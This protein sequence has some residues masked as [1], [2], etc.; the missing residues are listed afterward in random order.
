MIP[1]NLTASFSGIT[2]Y[3][4]LN[5][6]TLQWRGVPNG[7]ITAM[8][9]T[10]NQIAFEFSAG[11]YG[12][13]AD[14]GTMVALT[15]NAGTSGGGQPVWSA[16]YRGVT[17]DGGLVTGVNWTCFGSPVQNWGIAPIPAGL[18]TYPNFTT[19]PKNTLIYQSGGAGARF[20]QSGAT[21]PGYS[22]IDP[23]GNVQ[24]RPTTGTICGVSPPTWATIVG[25]ITIDGTNMWTNFG[26]IS[27][28]YA[29]TDYGGT[30]TNVPNPCCIIDSNGN[31][32][33]V[34]DISTMG[35]SGGSEPV[36]AT[37]PNTTTT[38]GTI[39][40]VCLGPG[41]VLWSGPFGYAYSFHSIDGSVSTASPVSLVLNGGIGPAGGYQ[42]ELR[43]AI[44]T[45][46]QVDQVWIWRTAQ[47]GA[48]LILLDIIPNVQEG[49]ERP[50]DLPGRFER[51]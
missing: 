47:N 8:A 16:A 24:A 36:W 18:P 27:P 6:Q 50:V 31:L 40:W 7:A 13:A 32:Q 41:A 34:Q 17:N 29:T 33:G 44:S 12:P 30:T 48:T 19:A 49:I 26:R 51:L 11:A 1:A 45:D 23:N 39:T 9:L 10:A 20:W 42:M 43:G 28:W 38:D 25:S 37:A 21:P 46:L 3:V 5:G 35:T 4:A 15:D 2:N 22:I 14:T